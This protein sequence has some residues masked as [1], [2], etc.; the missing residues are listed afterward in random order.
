[1]SEPATNSQ[2]YIEVTADDLPG[3][4]VALYDSYLTEPELVRLASW[5]RLER[6]PTGDLLAGHAVLWEPK[7]DGIRTLSFISFALV[8]RNVLLLEIDPCDTLCSEGT[9]LPS[10]AISRWV[11][12]LRFGNCC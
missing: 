10:F 12:P 1:M 2:R 4:A 9:S 6:V 5:Y 3:Y 8:M 11:N 7:L